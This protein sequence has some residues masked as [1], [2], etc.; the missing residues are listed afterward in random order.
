MSEDD[1]GKDDKE[2]NE[3]F[4]KIRD[5]IEANRKIFGELVDEID[6]LQTAILG[7]KGPGS[8]RL[9]SVVPEDLESLLR[10]IDPTTSEQS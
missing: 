8:P 7:S 1:K 3:R 4:A 10:N 9:L 6:E 2:L 5:L